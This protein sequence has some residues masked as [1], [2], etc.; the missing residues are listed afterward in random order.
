VHPSR[1]SGALTFRDVACRDWV[2]IVVISKGTFVTDSSHDQV[3]KLLSTINRLVADNNL[4]EAD[5]AM[6][7]VSQLTTC[8][9]YL[10]ESYSHL[11][12]SVRSAL[13]KLLDEGDEAFYRHWFSICTPNTPRVQQVTIS[14]ETSP[15]TITV[16]RR[17]LD[18]TDDRYDIVV[19]PEHPARKAFESL[20]M[21]MD[22]VEEGAKSHIK[23]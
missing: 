1:R 7:Y 14:N 17:L 5:A 3:L 16:I 10:A 9:S 6:I 15:P 2:T 23:D 22:S 12:H 18:P 8:P 19:E 4:S 11:S 21:H 20:R 13:R